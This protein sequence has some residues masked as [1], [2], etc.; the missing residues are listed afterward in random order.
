MLSDILHRE[1]VALETALQEAI[2][3]G[4]AAIPQDRRHLVPTYSD[5]RQTLA[6]LHAHLETL[7][8]PPAPP[9]LTELEKRIATAAG[10]TAQ[11][12]IAARQANEQR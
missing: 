2:T 4:I 7:S 3:A 8:Q 6:W 9:K 12:Y 5:P 10:M 11:E 1:R